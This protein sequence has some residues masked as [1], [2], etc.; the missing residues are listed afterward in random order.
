MTQATLLVVVGTS[1]GYAA[2]HLSR[3]FLN[4]LVGSEVSLSPIAAA[5]SSMALLGFVLLAAWLPA[6]RAARIDPTVALRI[7]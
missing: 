4:G 1:V 6:R 7:E 5:V 3:G 2:A